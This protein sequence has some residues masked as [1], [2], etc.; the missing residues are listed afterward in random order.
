MSGSLHL[1][2]FRKGV[3][4][5]TNPTAEDIQKQLEKLVMAAILSVLNRLTNELSVLNQ[6]KKMKF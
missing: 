3:D 2:Y 4:M 1:K 5:E 6:E